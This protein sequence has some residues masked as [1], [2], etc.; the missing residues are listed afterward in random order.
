MNNNVSV[1]SPNFGMAYKVGD[2]KNLSGYLNKQEPKAIGELSSKMEMAVEKLKNTKYADLILRADD[3]GKK[4]YHNL[5]YRAPIFNDKG[6]VQESL[7]ISS[8]F[9][10]IDNAVAEALEKEKAMTAAFEYAKKQEQIL[11]DLC[12]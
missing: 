8:L 7:V 6:L 12:K 9:G 2:L 10:D 1:Q 5:S 3:D 11:K 4:L